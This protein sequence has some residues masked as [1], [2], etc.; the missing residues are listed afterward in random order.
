MYASGRA[1]PALR[2]LA[3]WP[4]IPPGS[5]CRGACQ[6]RV[7]RL[8]LQAR[9]LPALRVRVCGSAPD[10]GSLPGLT[11]WPS[12]PVQV[13]FA[14]PGTSGWRSSRIAAPLGWPSRRL[15]REPMLSP[16][17]A[18][19]TA[20]FLASARLLVRRPV[21][22]RGVR[23]ATRGLCLRASAASARSAT[24]APA[25]KSLEGRG[26]CP[27]C[28]PARAAKTRTVALLYRYPEY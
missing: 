6:W 14:T 4:I 22:S 16:W 17:I 25:S 24:R 19:S 27:R 12:L 11:S 23:P 1:L 18:C 20:R 3:R 5:L 15:R 10:C 28:S 7:L 21:C 2:P 9:R 13:F 8:R 26:P